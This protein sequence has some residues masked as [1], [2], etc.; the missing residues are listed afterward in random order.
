MPSVWLQPSRQSW[1]RGVTAY[2]F[3]GLTVILTTASQVLQK[4][5]AITV[6]HGRAPVFLLY[7]REPLF[8]LAL[9]LL[10]FAMLSW[11]V[12]L[13]L[14]EVSKAYTLLSVNYALMV[15]VSRIVFAEQVPWTRWL[16]AFVIVLGVGVIS[17]H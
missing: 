10:G 5:V 3:L 16:G 13:D 11:L 8:W 17:W 1:G 15:P 6:P 12:V 9:V 2:L 4:Q 14:L 7:I